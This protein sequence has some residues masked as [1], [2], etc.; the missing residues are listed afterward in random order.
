MFATDQRSQQGELGIFD[1]MDTI[2]G[3]RPT[4]A[5]VALVHSGIGDM[6]QVPS[7]ALNGK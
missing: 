5:P 2:L 3:T 7:S 4:S 1:K 6:S